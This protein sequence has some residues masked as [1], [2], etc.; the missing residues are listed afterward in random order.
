MNAKIFV[1]VLVAVGVSSGQLQAATI[2]FNNI[3]VGTVSNYSVNGPAASFTLAGITPV[4]AIVP[5][6]FTGIGPLYNFSA[7]VTNGTSTVWEDFH[8]EVGYGTDVNYDSS[9]GQDQ[10][11]F[12]TNISSNQFVGYSLKTGGGEADAFSALGVYDVGINWFNGVVQE[13]DSVNLLFT[14]QANDY[15]DSQW[16]SSFYP[17]KDSKGNVIGF[18]LTFHAFPAL[19]SLVIPIPEPSSIILLA[20]GLVGLGAFSRRLRGTSAN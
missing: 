2:D 13:G 6:Y 7:T 20:V 10:P 15:A 12:L 19:E 4:E 9:T 14:L 5:M 16:N 3:H 1:I 8:F 11:L 17:I 18:N